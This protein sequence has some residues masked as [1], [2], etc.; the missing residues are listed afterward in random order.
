MMPPTLRKF[1]L[2]MAGL[3]MGLVGI[4]LGLWIFLQSA[5][6]TQI[7]S[8][9]GVELRAATNQIESVE[10]LEDDAI[11]I[12]LRDV[13]LLDESGSTIVEAP[14]LLLTLDVPSLN[15][16]GPIELYD[17][18][19]IDPS[20]DLRQS[21]SGEWNFMQVMAM[22]A[23][24]EPVEGG[25]GRP[26]LLRNVRL[27][28]GDVTIAMPA[29]PQ[30][31]DTDSNFAIDLPTAQI[32]GAAYQRYQLTNVAAEIP[33]I[34]FGGGE[35][36]R[37]DVESVVGQLEAPSLGE[38][39][40]ASGRIEQAGED[41]IRF[42]L[43]SLAVG[44]S[45]LGGEGVVRLADAG[46]MYDLSLRAAPIF[47]RDI[48]AL[49][50][51]L[52][53]EGRASFAAEIESLSTERHGLI[54][55]EMDLA[56][57]ESRV[58]GDFGIA[59]GGEAGPTLLAADLEIERVDLTILEDIGIVE[60]VPLLGMV[61]GTIRS[62][63]ADGSTAIVDLAGSVVPRDDPEAVPSNIV[64]YGSIALGD[65]SEPLQLDGLV[66]GFQ[67]LYLASLRGIVPPEQVDRL[68]GE[69]RGAL[70]LAGTLSE[71][72]IADGE[73]TYTVGQGTSTTL[74]GI[75]GRLLLDPLT[76]TLRASASPLA[77]A[78]V[79]EFFPA[80][81]FRDQTLSGPIELSG[82]VDGFD[83]ETD[84]T[85]P[86]GGIQLSGRVGLSPVTTFSVTGN[87]RAFAAGLVLSGNSPVEGPLTGSFSASGSTSYVTF[88]V[89][90]EQ[91]EGSFALMGTANLAAEP[92]RFDVAGN[93]VNFRIGALVGNPVLFPEPMSGPISI[94]GGGGDA[95]TF[96][97]DLQGG[98]GLLDLDGIYR[99]GPVPSYEVT[100][101]VAS[102]D[103]SG[104]P[105]PVRLPATGLS[106]RVDIHGSGTTLETLAGS[107]TF[108][109][110][111]SSVANLTLET[112]L[113]RIAVVDGIATVDTLHV[114]LQNS[115]LVAAG[116]WGL[117]APAAEPLRFSFSSPNLGELTRILA[118]GELIPPQL[119][120]SIRAQGRV[121]GSVEF[122]AIQG[123]LTGRGLRYGDWRA[124]SLDLTVD[125][126]R[127]PLVGWGGQIAASGDDLILPAVDAVQTI[128]MEASGN[129]ASLAVGM[130]ARRDANT[131]VAFSGLLEL[132]GLRPQGIGL[133]TLAL[134]SEGV[135]WDLLYPARLRYVSDEGL[136]IEGLS[137]RRGGLGSVG[138]VTID[139]MLPPT[140][141]TEL[142]V[143]A[144]NVDLS[145]LHRISPALPD[146]DG[147]L[148]FNLLLD[149]PVVDP[150]LT[151]DG[152]VTQFGYEGVVT[153][154]VD[155]SASYADGSLT[156]AVHALA[157]GRTLFEAIADVPARLSLENRLLPAFEFSETAP[158][159]AAIRADSLPLDIAAAMLP[160]V[161]TGAGLARAH[162]DVT[163]T[164]DTP[165]FQ[166][167]LRV[168]DGAVTVEAA[169][170]RY[171]GIQAD[172]Q[173]A[174]NQATIGNLVVVSGG[175]L[176][177]SGGV[178]FPTVSA[179]V[180]DISL[181]M[182]GFRLVND[183]ELAQLTASGQLAITGPV[184]EPV[185]RGQVEIHESTIRVPDM[186]Q[187]QPQLGLAYTD[188]G[189]QVG[190]LPDADIQIPVPV[191]G[192]VRVDG[193][194]VGFDESVWL[195]SSE[196][197]V[198]IEGAL[199]VYR[200][201]EEFRVYGDL[202]ALRG[203]YGLQVSGI[204]REFD[205]IS[206]RVQFFGTGEID[207]S[208]D[209]TAGYRVRAST[210]GQGGDITILVNL[211]GTLLA[212]RVALSSDTPVQLSEADL[213]SY[214]MFGQPSF[215]L[216]GVGVNF[217]QQ[218]FVQEFVGGI[219]ASELERGI[220]QAG[221][222]DWFR[223]RPGM[224]SSFSGLFARGAFANAA[225][226]CGRELAPSLYFTAQANLGGLFDRGET[227][228]QVGVEWEIDNQ[229]SVEAAY[230]ALQRDAIARIFD[231]RVPTQ[232]STDLRRQWE[233]G[234][235]SRRSVLDL[236]SDSAT[237]GTPPPDPPAPEPP[238]G[239]V[240]VP[241]N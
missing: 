138:T 82:T 46:P 220:L 122:P 156:G 87:L 219:L 173:F 17:V 93:V 153:E 207:P 194:S 163:G 236:R 186:G 30:E 113:G 60:Q 33:E 158:L 26:I 124:A 181:T 189:Q 3:G 137:I 65:A 6:E 86:A 5:R 51:F 70:S 41:G 15:R 121:A 136:L 116:S 197:R 31:P 188:I 164:I 175:T 107:Y 202:A 99:P 43:G 98:S 226:E 221:L 44:E 2:V 211:T 166:G 32:D 35:P 21:P 14:R 89:D 47:T 24:G 123:D 38:V 103:V 172:I 169:G 133:Q 53:E 135:E 203:T 227:S 77:L 119:A 63:G 222:C 56:I 96:N 165:V 85:G 149:G 94:A 216:G 80:L 146:V 198:Q 157:A 193:V 201:G 200:L 100:G 183:P 88:D 212:P 209:I 13:A 55:R 40:L 148:T 9:I 241:V 45:R 19:L 102:L 237:V 78:T 22:T 117:R 228:G 106:G 134:R 238:P 141:N 161:H 7:R 18:E 111:D 191:F 64:A 170:A 214:L 23:G 190:P 48:R 223:V 10:A 28:R 125:V 196:M 185:V 210:I 69:V 57:G 195:E 25:G 61:T 75:D 144:E 206:G 208:L 159:V 218:V 239:A 147:L 71:L 129:E 110:T 180:L 84:L 97:V 132:S 90:F 128:R 81:P 37:V 39:R 168:D 72:R 120:G 213:I 215:E 91:E 240:E 174:E 79:T 140:G 171:S 54:F 162:I 130:F 95:Y 167:W 92:A 42:D 176:T 234:R 29:G 52:P 108:D 115:V 204:V 224:T 27:T 4:S 16:E 192:N 74:T 36:W 76:Y 217:A 187:G 83:L 49:L 8:A 105:T 131:E 230:G 73:L 20:A 177:A 152:A 182:N 11:R 126:D 139:G 109:L 178:G 151:I 112:A 143:A 184:A 225:V 34:V 12:T 114:Q 1:G 154:R 232:F 62:D 101:S 199:I 142:R 68:R 235:P 66:V 104:L 50:P 179:P 229:W 145:D 127:D 67:P 58:L 150:L 233:Y 59:I 155:L 160:G 205:V 231:S 118:P